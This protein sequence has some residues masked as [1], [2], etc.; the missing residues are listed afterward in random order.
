MAYDLIFICARCES[1]GVNVLEICSCDKNSNV[2]IEA[3]RPLLPVVKKLMDCGI[4]VSQAV[5]KWYLES[6]AGCIKGF[7]NIT[8]FLHGDYED[9]NWNLPKLFYSC[10]DLT[11]AWG[12]KE[13]TPISV[14]GNYADEQ[15][16]YF[17]CLQESTSNPKSLEKKSI[18]SLCAWAESL[19]ADEIK[20]Q[21]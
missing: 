10:V 14:H 5:S 15:Y 9:I 18:K 2:F 8:L 1:E 12:S 16:G 4:K 21:L 17:I 7:L 11:K 13:T 6:D 3:Y 19:S 20:L